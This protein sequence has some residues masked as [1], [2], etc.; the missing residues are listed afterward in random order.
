MTT[1]VQWWDRHQIPL[2]VAAI[3]LGAVIGA[4]APGISPALTVAINPVL[5]LLLFAT[6]L[7]VPLAEVGRSFRDIRFLGTVLIINFV[8]VPVVVFGLSRFVADDR[9]LLIGVLL[10]LLT[11]CVDYVIVFTGLAGGAQA[12]LLA[13]APLL[14]LL[15]ILLLP[16]YLLLF[17]GGDAVGLIEIEPFVEAF[18]VLIVA[19][20]VAAAI[21]QATARRHHVGRVIEEV[22]AGAMVPLMMLTLAV[23]NGSQIAAVGGETVTL[24]RVVPLYIAFLAIM[25]FIGLAAGRIARLDNPATRAVIFSGSTRNSLVVLPLALALPT[26]LGIAPLAVV[27][28]TLVELVGMVIFVRLVPRL[29]TK[30]PSRT[31]R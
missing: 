5:A 20:L 18:L 4:I 24:L 2:Y 26:A 30:L 15:Q 1:A 23:V 6:F 12:R 8:I 19:P 7:A 29:T 16:L 21:V 31:V 11:P 22:M 25:L 28:Q 27:T 17:A 9:G 13:A 10:V 14:M 3:V